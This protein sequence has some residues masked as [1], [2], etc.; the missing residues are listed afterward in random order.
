MNLSE[1]FTFIEN[2]T[3]LERSLGKSMRPYR[4]DRMKILLKLFDN[5][6]RAFNTVHIAGSKGKGSTGVYIASILSAA[7]YKTGLYTSPHVESYTERITLAGR[8]IGDDVIIHSVETIERKLADKSGY[9]L[10]GNSD[11]TTFELL[12]LSAMLSFRTAGCTWAAIE[13][14]IGG[15]LDATNLVEPEVTV[16]TPIELEHTEILGTTIPEIAAEKGGI[17]KAGVPVFSS[18]QHPEAEEVLRWIATERN[19]PFVSISDRLL[20][21]DTKSDTASTIAELRWSDGRSESFRLRMHGRVQ[22]DNAALGALVA[23]HILESLRVPQSKR[24]D[25]RRKGIESA[26]LPGRME[27]IGSAPMIVLDAA[28]TPASVARL[29]DSF[30]S[31][32]PS[33]RVLV[34]GSVLGKN[35]EAMSDVLAP[36]FDHIVISTPG[37]FKKSDPAAVFESFARRHAGVVLERDPSEAFRTAIERGGGTAPIL[38]TGSFYMIGE[39]RG[40]ALERAQRIGVSSGVSSG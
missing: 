23:D 8:D 2:F 21:A 32:F 7:G 14:G 3:N 16:I 19:A 40:L 6:H 10:P 12:T 27:I 34:F 4:L 38:V 24:R 37:T 28:H 22:A 25:A 5:P 26:L 18:L 35:Q 30:T 11:P 36:L 17:I 13:T 1:A 20:S 31:M 15:R 9:K 29:A 39:I 33:P